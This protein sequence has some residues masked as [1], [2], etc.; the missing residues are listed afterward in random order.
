VG[1]R[2]RTPMAAF[3]TV[4]GIVSHIKAHTYKR[5]VSSE[6]NRKQN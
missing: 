4:L 5:L 3:Q 6:L 2:R 1:N